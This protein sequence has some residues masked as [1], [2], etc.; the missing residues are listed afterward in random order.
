[1]KTFLKN[2]DNDLENN[3]TSINQNNDNSIVNTDSSLDDNISLKGKWYIIN[4]IPGRESKILG[5]IKEEAIKNSID[6]KIYDIF[7]PIENYTSIA[8]G[9]RRLVSKKV[10]PGYIMINVDLDERIY[11]I[12]RSIPDVL[13]FL[14]GKEPK[15][16]PENQVNTLKKSVELMAIKNMNISIYKIGDF[17][18]IL[19]G[20]FEGFTALIEEVDLDK[21]NLKVAVSIFGRETT[22]SVHFNQVYIIKE[23]HY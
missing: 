16:V 19:D 14:G 12:L 18:K 9:N 11:T 5:L 3:I 1:M 8:R 13:G 23:Q 21:K 17:V 4:V 15:V 7:M 22:I 6:D 20:P 2:S 10:L